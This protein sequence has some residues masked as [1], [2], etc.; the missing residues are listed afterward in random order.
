MRHV[1]SERLTLTEDL[2]P[3]TL[4]LA[5]NPGFNLLLTLYLHGTLLMKSSSVRTYNGDVGSASLP[6]ACAPNSPT[7]TN[8]SHYGLSAVTA[9]APFARA[10]C[11]LAPCRIIGSH[12]FCPKAICVSPACGTLQPATP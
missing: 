6:A 3:T 10:C 5:R 8:V 1:D 12:A 4:C 9:A 2:V 7:T 11:T